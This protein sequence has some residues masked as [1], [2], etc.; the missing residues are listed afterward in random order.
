MIRGPSTK[1]IFRTVQHLLQYDCH[2][3]IFEIDLNDHTSTYQI[4]ELPKQS[5]FILNYLCPET[6][7]CGNNCILVAVA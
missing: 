5:V 3:E 1:K 6:I 7:I 4:Q 2:S